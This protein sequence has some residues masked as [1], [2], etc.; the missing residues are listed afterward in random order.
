M[1]TAGIIL[2]GGL[3]RRMG[4]NEKSLMKLAGKQPAVPPISCLLL[5]LPFLLVLP[6]PNPTTIGRGCFR[7]AASQVSR[8]ASSQW[9]RN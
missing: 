9:S 3:S 2:A 6:G 8:R 1:N 4:G 7:A 5:L